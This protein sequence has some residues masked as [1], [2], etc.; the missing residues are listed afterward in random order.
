MDHK[1]R[2]SNV[3]TLVAF[4][5]I[6]CPPSTKI[7]VEDKSVIN[8]STSLTLAPA[9][10]QL[11]R[12]GLSFIPTST[13]IPD[14]RQS[15][16]GHIQQYHR[17]LKLASHFRF[18][19]QPDIPPFRLKSNWEPPDVSLPEDLLTLIRKDKKDLAHLRLYPEKPNL[20]QEEEKALRDLK[21]LTTIIIK[22]A[23]KGSA[24][25]IMD[26]KDYVQ[27]AKRQL[28][29]TTYYQKLDHPI[30]P[31]TA[32]SVDLILN[33]L[34]D[35]KYLSRSQALYLKGQSPPRP[36]YFYLLPKIHKNPDSWTVPHKIP[37]GRP[38]I[39][40]C[41]SESYGTAELLDYFLNP[42]SIKHPSY[43]KDTNDFID[44]VK[45]LSLP[46]HCFLFTMDVESLYTNI[47]TQMGI[48]AI[49][50]IFGK[51]PDPSRPDRQL[52]ELLHLN[53]TC[54]DFQF[55]GENFLQ[56]KGTAMGKR[57]S[58]AYANIYMADWEESAFLE[59][60]KLPIIYLRYLDD[61]WGIWTHTREDF[62]H[63]VTNLNNHH[64]SINLQPVLHCTEINF[65]D[66]TTFKGP[67]FPLTGQ[68]DV[69]VYFKPTDAHALL[70]KT[71]F[72]PRHTFRGIIYSQLL[73][74]QRICTR[75]EDRNKA[76]ET[77]FQA[78]RKR[79]YS[80]TFLRKIRKQVLENNQP[81][82]LIQE[83]CKSLIPIVSV[84]SSHSVRAHGILK[85]NFQTL[86]QTR[87][88]RSILKSCLPTRKTQTSRIS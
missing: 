68:L 50:K 2:P 63:F 41:G 32:Q 70:H 64:P 37:P 6:N 15:L 38:I 27:E 72:H 59:C 10:L 3:G 55:N 87:S 58:P 73:R 11:L 78:M 35:N 84:Y 20:N 75:A 30:Y 52:L 13:M 23:D 60:P 29:N 86:M 44:R 25:V 45:S 51:Y 9:H 74:F 81:T 22:P 82:R 65:L 24:V 88:S 62:Q 42:L 12:K 39:S 69:R 43:I 36:R 83:S 7:S 40:D 67:N 54:N 33:D 66:T 61:I 18:S 17:R 79:G 31:Q 80:R 21:S 76:T 56:I 53:L 85:N 57:F 26:R 14:I 77:L 47:D 19:D 48:R 8:L 49:Q 4:F 34:V 1:H 28:Q 5:R 71:S 46:K 16:A